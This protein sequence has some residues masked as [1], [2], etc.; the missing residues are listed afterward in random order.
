MPD[1]PTSMPIISMPALRLEHRAPIHAIRRNVTCADG[2][3]G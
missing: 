1:P 2:G 3:S